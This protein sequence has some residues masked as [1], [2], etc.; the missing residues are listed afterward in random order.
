MCLIHIEYQ[1]YLGRLECAVCH[2]YM[3][4]A[5]RPYAETKSCR[6]E[7]HRNC[8]LE[9]LGENTVCPLCRMDIFHLQAVGLGELLPI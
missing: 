5:D 2:E 7:F 9:W 4:D 8:L 6:H 3:T 1:E